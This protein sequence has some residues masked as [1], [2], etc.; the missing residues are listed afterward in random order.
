[1]Q[2]ADEGTSD[3]VTISDQQTT[4]FIPDVNVYQNKKSVSQGLMDFALLVTN[5]QQLRYVIESF[6]RNPY[7]YI[8]VVMILISM[9]LQIAVGIGLLV[10]SRYN[11]K[12]CDD[13]CKADRINN[14]ITVGIFLITVINVIISAFGVPE[15]GF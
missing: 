14:F 9:V 6:D 1:M 2:H 7:F 12:D 10:N 5:V 8:S 4:R 11:I 3:M 15:K 13:I